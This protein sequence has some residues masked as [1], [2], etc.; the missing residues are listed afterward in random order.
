MSSAVC[1]GETMA[2]LTPAPGGPLHLADELLFGIDGTESNVVMGLAAM[3]VQAHRVGRVGR[4]GF[5][6]RTLNDL[7]AHGVG[8]SDV[9]MDA[10]RPTGLYVKVPPCRSG[11]IR[12]TLRPLQPTR[13]RSVGDGT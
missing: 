5:G 7:Q 12:R 13:L 10:R 6:T 3:G 8:I 1:I 9:E 4:D 11:S 2:M